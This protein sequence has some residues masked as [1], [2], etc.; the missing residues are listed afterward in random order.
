[1]SPEG[2]S[3]DVLWNQFKGALQSGIEL[4]VPQ[5][6]ESTK[7]SLPWITKELKRSIQKLGSL[8]DKYKRLRRPSDR[9]AFV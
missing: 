4:F 3:I 2:K 1:M 5:R 6:T 9:H 7:S 8:Y